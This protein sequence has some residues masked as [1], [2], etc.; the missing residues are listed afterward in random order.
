MKP[1]ITFVTRNARKFEEA[2]LVVSDFEVVQCDVHLTEIQGEPRAIIEHKISEA[3]KHV[4]S[5]FFVDDTLLHFE[6]LHGL[7]GPYINDF[8]TKLGADGLYRLLKDFDNKN[9]EA[10]A[11]I[12]CMTASGKTYIVEGRIKGT[13]VAPRGIVAFGWDPIFQPD[14]FDQTF[15][16]MGVAGK[17]QISHRSK[18]LRELT[19]LLKTN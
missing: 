6:A 13:I 4:K 11:M 1:H 18:A 3:A 9:A 15:A 12:G 10:V 16:E 2:Q 7:P 14:G 8:S 19:D 17:A 5:P